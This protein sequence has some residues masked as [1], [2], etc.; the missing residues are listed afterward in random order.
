MIFTS[1]DSIPEASTERRCPLTKVKEGCIPSSLIPR[2]SGTGSL[3]ESKPP[4]ISGA[5]GDWFS[6]V[7]THNTITIMRV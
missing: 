3:A 1:H 2:D 7:Y 5:T 4:S 6:T